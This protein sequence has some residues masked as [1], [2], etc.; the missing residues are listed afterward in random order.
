MGVENDVAISIGGVEKEF[1]QRTNVLG[2]SNASSNM[3][4]SM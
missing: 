3:I 4:I 2:C 1:I